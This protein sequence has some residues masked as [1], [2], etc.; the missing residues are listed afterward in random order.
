M[1]EIIE[2]IEREIIEMIEMI[3]GSKIIEMI[4]FSSLLII[5]KTP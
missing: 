4:D 1:R 5:L 2:M 3:D